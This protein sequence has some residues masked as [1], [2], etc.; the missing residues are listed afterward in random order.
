MPYQLTYDY[1]RSDLA[2]HS[3]IFIRVFWCEFNASAL[4]VSF[5]DLH[6]NCRFYRTCT[7]FFGERVE[8]SLAR[9][10]LIYH[11]QVDDWEVPI[12][13]CLFG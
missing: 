6:T 13:P 2:I 8:L 1:H 9:T 5:L 12:G 10:E 4:L 11:L 3:S 7:S